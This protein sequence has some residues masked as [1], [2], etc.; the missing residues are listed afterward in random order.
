MNYNPFK[1]TFGL[2]PDNYIERLSQSQEII[3]T[4]ER[5]TNNVY[6]I[7]GLR[8]SGKTALLTHI[9]NHFENQKDWIVVELQSELHML[10]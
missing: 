1:T 3:N 6:M 4:F 5:N 2:K 10:D 8:G 7:T 9:S